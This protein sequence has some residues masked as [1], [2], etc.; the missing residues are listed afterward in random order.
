LITSTP[1]ATAVSIAAARSEV[2][3]PASFQRALYAAIRARGAIPLTTPRSTP[4]IDASTP[5]LPAAV[6]AVWVPWPS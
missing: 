2:N 6:E 4:K 5:A 3:P 1:S